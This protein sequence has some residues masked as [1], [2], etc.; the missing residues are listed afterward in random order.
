[1]K[2]FNAVSTIVS[3]L[4]LIIFPQ[5]LLA[6]DEEKLALLPDDKRVAFVDS[7]G[8]F[9]CYAKRGD[10]KMATWA[11]NDNAL[12][13]NSPA[14]D[15]K[16]IQQP[17]GN[18]GS[19]VMRHIPVELNNSQVTCEGTFQSGNRQ[20]KSAHLILQPKLLSPGDVTGTTNTKL[21]TGQI[22]V[23]SEV[24]GVSLASEPSEPTSSVSTAN[25][26]LLTPLPDSESDTQESTLP[27]TI[28]LDWKAPFR[29]RNAFA[30]PDIAY[31][32]D[33]IQ[34]AAP[35]FE[36]S[37]SGSGLNSGEGSAPT[38]TYH[39]YERLRYKEGYGR[40]RYP[41]PKPPETGVVSE[42][43]WTFNT[44]TEYT[45]EMTAEDINENRYRFKITPLG[46][47]DDA[48]GLPAE[49]SLKDIIPE[50][51][52]QPLVQQKLMGY[53]WLYQA[54][55]P[56]L[57]DD[58]NRTISLTDN[59]MQSV[60]VIDEGYSDGIIW[61]SVSL[62]QGI[63]QTYQLSILGISNG[64]STTTI[65]NYF[66]NS[67][68]TS[69]RSTTQSMDENEEFVTDTTSHPDQNNQ[70]ETLTYEQFMMIQTIALSLILSL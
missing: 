2:Y 39:R 67:E 49:I 23:I 34:E 54:R 64:D 18:L 44:H 13:E 19:L 9:T 1:M 5:A 26:S 45:L 17:V 61:F 56:G 52:I 32:I 4:I 25:V 63:N 22:D 30:C 55:V 37:V 12:H 58:G 51:P 10:L 69:S 21:Y 27:V 53:E 38:Q 15:I 11:I 36:S 48:I 33:L 62:E 6:G 41:N 47:G 46:A 42:S 40:C 70:A 43:R 28:R 29:F 60:S 3:C 59:K 57:V 7:A 24:D 8:S 68:L 31:R 50:E 20:I 66:Q 14:V 35:D 16:F 65:E